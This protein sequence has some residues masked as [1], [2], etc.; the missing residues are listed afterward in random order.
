MTTFGQ[1]AESRNSA[2]VWMFALVSSRTMTAVLADGRASPEAVLTVIV[3][4]VCP[5]TL[6]PVALFAPPF[7]EIKATAVPMT[8]ALFWPLEGRRHPVIVRP[9]LP[10]PGGQRSRRPPCHCGRPR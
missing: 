9:V 4:V 1:P 6:T 3:V 8:E 7:Q 10:D 5:V 2:I